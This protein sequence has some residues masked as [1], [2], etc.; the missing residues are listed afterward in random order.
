MRTREPSEGLI[1]SLSKDEAVPARFCGGTNLPHPPISAPVAAGSAQ[2]GR[3]WHDVAI[4]IGRAARARNAAL[5]HEG[6]GLA[7]ARLAQIEPTALKP[8]EVRVRLVAA[9]LNHRDLWTC[10]GRAPD[11]PPVVLGSDGAGI[12][13]ETGSAV[14]DLEPGAEVVINPSLHWTA[15][16]AAPPADFEILGHPTHGTFAETVAVPRANVEPRPRHLSWEEAAALPL[17]GLTAY[18][19]L[20]TKG[21]LRSGDA[22]VIPGIGGGTALQAMQLAVAAGARVFVTSTD[23][24]KRDRAVALGATA[25][26]DSALDWAAAV[27]AETQGRGADI[28]VESVGAPTWTKSLGCLARGGRIVVYGSTAGDK[29]ELDLPPFFLNWRSVLG[30]TMGN[31]A[32]FRAMLRFVEQH[33]LKPVV[34]RA[35]PLEQGIEALRILEAGRQMGKIVLRIAGSV[36]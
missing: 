3:P 16:A 14:R 9:A 26:Y 13:A 35:L 27:L 15:G 21:G 7:G 11:L 5:V 2:H 30:T 34:D 33:R 10:R 25:A 1:L 20:F 8:G 24:A 28:V 18:R 19:A 29:V 23:P 6:R 17:S 31:R 22:V 32:E 12:V 4:H 36:P